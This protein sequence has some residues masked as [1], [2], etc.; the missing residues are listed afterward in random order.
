MINKVTLVGRLGKDAEVRQIENGKVASFD[1]A[2]T[3][4]WKD[5]QGQWK[6][7]VEW[8]RVVTF[9]EGLCDLL[10]EKALKG[11]LVY[12]EGVLRHRNYEHEGQKVYVTEVRIE[13]NGV[14]RFLDTLEKQEAE[15]PA[16]NSGK[17]K[18]K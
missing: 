12:I 9:Q 1:V 13:Q 6:E 8:H 7:R 17:S 2:T 10:E 4:A 5:D 11:R 3:E 14:V 16:E 18:K 15:A